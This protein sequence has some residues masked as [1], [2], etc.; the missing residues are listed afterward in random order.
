MG[1]EKVVKME[2]VKVYHKTK[3]GSYTTMEEREVVPPVPPPEKPIRVGGRG[4]K[5]PMHVQQGVVADRSAGLKEREV[6]EKWGIGIRAVSR[7]WSRFNKTLA[8]V[9]NQEL[10]KDGKEVMHIRFRKKPVSAVEDAL[11]CRDNLYKRGDLGE[12]I[13]VGTGDLRSGGVV[14]NNF[15]IVAQ[16]PAEWRSRYIGIEDGEEKE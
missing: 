8:K 5:V 6:A 15:N 16:T 2:T 1:E 3:M 13:L 10:L 11:D 7:V 14:V 12:K 9:E 4:R